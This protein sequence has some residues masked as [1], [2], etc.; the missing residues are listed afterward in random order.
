MR[1]SKKTRS[2]FILDENEGVITASLVDDFD[3]SLN[4]TIHGMPHPRVRAPRRTK[5]QIVSDSQFMAALH[6]ETQS[7]FLRKNIRGVNNEINQQIQEVRKAIRRIQ[8][9]T[10]YVVTAK[11]LIEDFETTT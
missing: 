8:S 10:H 11:E 2:R 4:Q 9:L 1:K 6:H 3:Y 7:E 5:E